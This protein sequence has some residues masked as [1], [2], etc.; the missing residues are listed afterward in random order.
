MDVLSPVELG[1]DFGCWEVLQQPA[2]LELFA[3]QFGW[4]VISHRR[5]HLIGRRVPGVGLIRAKVFSPEASA[6]AEWHRALEDLPAGHIEVMTNAT[7][8]GAAALP[9]SPSDLYS[10]VVDLRRG[11]DALFASFKAQTRNAIRRGLRE[12]MRV[13]ATQERSD[14]SKFYDVLQRVTRNGTLYDVPDLC[15]LRSIMDAGFGRLYVIG[16][17]GETFGGMFLL[18][19]VYSHAYLLA[20]DRKASNRLPGNLLYWGAM[21]GEIEAGVPFLD[22]GA[23][24]LSEDPARLNFTKRGFSPYLVP[25]FRYQFTAC[26]WRAK[27]DVALRRLFHA[28]LEMPA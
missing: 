17:S 6:G 22:L 26:R 20:F 2:F 13:Q 27:L 9:V 25:A 19:H 5:V 15:L 12:G 4:S 7:P 28:D 11:S 24:S 18:T 14:L 16:R 3:R 21:Q 8:H 23:Q 1:M 10:F